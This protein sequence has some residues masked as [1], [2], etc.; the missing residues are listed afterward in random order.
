[1]AALKRS[2]VA[3]AGFAAAL[4]AGGCLSSASLAERTSLAEQGLL[5]ESPGLFKKDD[6]ARY[7]TYWPEAEVYYSAWQDRYHWQN[8]YGKWDS[9]HLPPAGI[10]LPADESVMVQLY[11]A[12][13]HTEHEHVVAMH[14]HLDSIVDSGTTVVAVP[15]SY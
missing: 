3:A 1:M 11:T 14:P 7:Y 15:T 4:A 5:R 13:P 6:F 12:R 2:I 10:D 8:G 9:S